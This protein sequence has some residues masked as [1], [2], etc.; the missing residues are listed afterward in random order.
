MLYIIRH[1]MTDWNSLRILQGQTDIALNEEGRQMAIDARKDRPAQPF[2]ICFSSPLVRAK[3][4]A[5]L[6]L[7]GTKTPIMV[8][9]RLKELGFGICEGTKHAARNP[10]SP[11]YTLFH[12]PE[13][14]Q[15]VEGGET[16]DELFART[17]QFL[18]EEILPRHKRGERI[19]IVGHGAMNCSIISQLKNTERAHF[20]NHMTKNCELKL[21]LE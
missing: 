12:A 4:T 20:W 11:V 9:E 17:G 16:L 19:L 8:D 7:E 10:E 3:E 13:Q 1:G 2:D 15:G 6:F 21:I 14:Y 5:E 18:N